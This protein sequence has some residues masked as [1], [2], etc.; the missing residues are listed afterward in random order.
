[1]DTDEAWEQFCKDSARVEKASLSEKLDTM[2]AALN[3]IRIDAARTAQIVPSIMGD[4]AAVDTANAAAPMGE[5]P[6]PGVPPAEGGGLPP[7]DGAEGGAPPMDGMPGAG[8]DGTGMDDMAGDAMAGK[9]ELPPEMPP[10]MPPGGEGAGPMPADA[11]AGPVPPAAEDAAAPVQGVDGAA[12]EPSPEGDGDDEWTDEDDAAFNELMASLGLG[13]AG[14]ASSGEGTPAATPEEGAPEGEAPIE[15]AP[16]LGA[17]SVPEPA[18]GEDFTTDFNNRLKDALASAVD[19]G[20]STAIA[21][22][23]KLGDKIK[24]LL[25][26]F[27]AMANGGSEPAPEAVPEADEAIT[28]ADAAE[29]A[30]AAE[31]DIT[32]EE[33]PEGESKDE[34]EDKSEEK[35]D[36][37][38]EKADDE[39]DD[40]KKS[41]ECGDT[42]SI[43][44]EAGAMGAGSEGASNALFSEGAAK[45]DSDDG[46][47]KDPT[48]TLV[49]SVPSFSSMMKGMMDSALLYDSLDPIDGHTAIAKQYNDRAAKAVDEEEIMHPEGEV[50]TDF[51]KSESMVPDNS[52][53]ARSILEMDLTGGSKEGKTPIDDVK[54]AES[55]PSGQKGHQDPTSIATAEPIKEVTGDEKSDVG[56]AK[57]VEI[58]SASMERGEGAGKRTS[59]T[60]PVV[61]TAE[62]NGKHIMSFREMMAFAKSGRPGTMCAVNGDITTPT[63]GTSSVAKSSEHTFKFGQ[64]PMGMLLADCDRYNVFKA[65]D[66]F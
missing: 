45:Q 43:E 1:M 46:L 64:D 5:E 10:E 20:D 22:L 30:P 33:A 28:D 39:K 26:E 6:S 35:D 14:G 19:R 52:W 32:A 66:S 49:K 18:V 61:K 44:K 60:M 34:S 59:V 48:D 7:A 21:S 4:N 27:D 15:G 53:L 2:L 16:E 8:S 37:S 23:G 50:D 9:E 56:E 17:E 25:S 62:E 58:P 24:A 54:T 11:G 3:E 57:Q 29:P 51:A 42:E 55:I 36:K 31:I 40:I 38:E 63:Y 12:E 47:L 13:G 41:A 65:K